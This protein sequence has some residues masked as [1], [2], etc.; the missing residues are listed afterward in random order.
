MKKL[1][2]HVNTH[3]IEKSHNHS[4]VNQSK[5]RV[6]CSEPIQDVNSLI[7]V[8]RFEVLANENDDL[9]NDVDCNASV[10]VQ[11]SDECECPISKSMSVSTV[12]ENVHQ[13][14]NMSYLSDEKV[15]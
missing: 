6:I 11:V 13:G 2:K 5:H 4:L 8:N 15:L 1:A 12:V 10:H 9:N 14:K 3:C 7:H